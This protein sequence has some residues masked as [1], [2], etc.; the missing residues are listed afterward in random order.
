LKLRAPER[1][2]GRRRARR[3]AARSN[4]ALMIAQTW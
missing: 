4:G 3:W 1:R 2:R